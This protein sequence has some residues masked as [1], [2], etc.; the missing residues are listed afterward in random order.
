MMTSVEINSNTAGYV[1]RIKRVI[2]DRGIYNRQWGL[3]PV[4]SERRTLKAQGKLDK[5]GR[6]NENTPK[7]WNQKF[8]DYNSTENPGAAA[9]QPVAP[10]TDQQ[11]VEMAPPVDPS[12]GEM[13]TNGVDSGDD[14]DGDKKKSK[15]RKHADEDDAERKQRK[16]DKKARKAE[17]E[18]RKSDKSAA[19]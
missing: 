3:G 15:K 5:Y 10:T 11:D 9:A 7:E 6:A 12:T 16:A 2:M 18:R 1:A 4:A 13:V 14:D 17:K 19:E 8:V